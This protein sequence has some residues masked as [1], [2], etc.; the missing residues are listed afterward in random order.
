MMDNYEDRLQLMKE[1]QMGI[2]ENGGEDDD[3]ELETDSE[4]EDMQPQ[5][6]KQMLKFGKVKEGTATVVEVQ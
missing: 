6:K 2:V 4:A 5:P 3:A 1:M